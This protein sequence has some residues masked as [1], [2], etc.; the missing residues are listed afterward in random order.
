MRMGGLIL[1]NGLQ[2]EKCFIIVTVVVHQGN[3]VVQRR[4]NSQM[5]CVGF[6]ILGQR[7]LV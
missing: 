2:P 7:A 4:N 6:G 3:P 5:L 1:V